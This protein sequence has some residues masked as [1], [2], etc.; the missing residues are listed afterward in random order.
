MGEI[1][2]SV[3]ETDKIQFDIGTIQYENDNSQK[4][5]NLNLILR[6]FFMKIRMKTVINQDFL[7]LNTRFHIIF[8]KHNLNFSPVS[9][10]NTQFHVVSMG[11]HK[12]KTVQWV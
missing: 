10:R 6:S 8:Q 12:H 2:K 3:Q 7:I 1:A 9:L 4:S 5:T 11:K